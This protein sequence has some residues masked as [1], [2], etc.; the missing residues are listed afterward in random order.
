LPAE[1]SALKQRIAGRLVTPADDDFA[2]AAFGGQWN[3]LI[4]ERTPDAVVRVDNEDDVAEVV[5]FAG[6][7]GLKVAV[8]GGGHNWCGPA[9]RN[10]GMLI[11]LANLNR[12]VSLDRE[13]RRAVVQPILSNREVQAALNERGLSYPTGHCPQ[14]KLSGYLLGG[15]MSWN[16]GAWGEG[17]QSV[18][19]IDLV[20]PEGELITASEDENPDFFWAARGAGSNMFAVAVRFHLRLHPLPEAIWTSAHH[21]TID[22][23]GAVADWLGSLAG[24]LS[25][26]VE[27]TLFLLHAPPE[28][29][30]RCESANGKVCMV[31]ATVFAD[32]EREAISALEPLQ[33]CPVARPIAAVAPEA[34]D[35]PSLFDLSGSM[36][37]EGIRN[38]VDAMYYDRPAA[39]LVGA[40]VEHFVETPSE[41]TLLLFALFTGPDVPAPLPDAA[42]SMSA[43]IYGGPWTM[44]TEAADDAANL[45]WHARCVDALTP[46]CKG[47]YIGESDTVGHPEF[48][49][50]AYS[51]ANWRRLGELRRKHDSEGMFFTHSEGLD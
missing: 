17:F 14:V 36:W 26:K 50:R 49:E 33:D 43:R 29:A 24:E 2:E 6:P 38:Q 16:Q 11:D 9:L 28:L 30:D 13:S 1:L 5:R 32:S 7:N 19:A 42:F 22:D 21:F 3:R 35:F 4:P 41:T 27:L 8:R 25:P 46:L 18:E 10:G 23:A 34:T 40:S 31:T 44:W 20:T 45:E 39:E 12:I 15:G 48:A 47:H 37:P 51:A